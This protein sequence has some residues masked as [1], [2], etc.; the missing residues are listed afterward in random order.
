IGIAYS[1]VDMSMDR[2]H[3]RSL[4][5]KAAFTL[6]HPAAQGKEL[7]SQRA[8]QMMSTAIEAGAV[9]KDMAQVFTDDYQLP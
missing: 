9:S 3:P 1:L 5:A 8:E 7:A 6:V 4:A 2:E